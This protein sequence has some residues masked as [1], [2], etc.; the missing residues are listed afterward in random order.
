[1]THMGA[2]RTD[3]A[4]RRRTGH[5]GIGTVKTM[6][7]IPAIIDG[8]LDSLGIWINHHQAGP[9]PHQYQYWSAN[10]TSVYRGGP[11][12]LLH[13]SVHSIYST[14]HKA[15]QDEHDQGDDGH[16]GGRRAAR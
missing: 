2:P 12:S 16:V 8:G 14:Y 7:S 13:L 3:S 1:M 4:R 5:G 9:E 11:R 15:P 6:K 10:K